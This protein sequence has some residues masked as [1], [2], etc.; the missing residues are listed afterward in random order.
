MLHEHTLSL[1]RPFNAVHSAFKSA[2]IKHTPEVKFGSG[3]KSSLVV[4]TVKSTREYR[5]HQFEVQ[6]CLFLC[7]C[8]LPWLFYWLNTILVF[9]VP[10]TTSTSRSVGNSMRLSVTN[11]SHKMHTLHRLGMVQHLLSVIDDAVYVWMGCIKC[12]T[13][14][15]KEQFSFGAGGKV[16]HTNCITA[17]RPEDLV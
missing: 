7:F 9:S 5:I 3:T 16:V 1:Q 13:V 2:L 10:S 12:S 11:C 6:L 8:L 15:R 17:K 14:H 4:L